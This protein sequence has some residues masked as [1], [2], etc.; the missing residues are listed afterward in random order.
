MGVPCISKL[1]GIPQ[2]HTLTRAAARKGVDEAARV[3]SQGDVVSG[4]T[5]VAR[6]IG[7]RSVA[8]LLRLDT[9]VGAYVLGVGTAAAV[10][11]VRHVVL[12]E[13]RLAKKSTAFYGRPCVYLRLLGR[14][15]AVHAVAAH[16]VGTTE[17]AGR[18]TPHSKPPTAAEHAATAVAPGNLAHNA[19]P[20][21]PHLRR[22][23]GQTT[24]A[25]LAGAGS[26]APR[27][28]PPLCLTGSVVLGSRLLAQQIGSEFIA[29][30]LRDH[31]VV[32]F[33]RAAL[34]PQLEPAAEVEHVVSH[35]PT[36]GEP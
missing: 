16:S 4:A 10:P 9:R 32:L 5:G 11:R 28:L 8:R 19:P 21:R 35:L 3:I 34:E 1:P 31:R 27:D 18:E 17:A 22:G 24:R 30:P 20:G 7:G 25:T 26:H 33:L 6:R 23:H 36:P 13:Q 14:K 12:V 29:Y 15:A 2:G